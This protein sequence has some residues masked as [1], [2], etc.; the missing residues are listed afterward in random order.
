MQT[1]P[2]RAHEYQALEAL[3]ALDVLDT[4]PEAEFDA[5]VRVASLVC[6]APISLISLV[7]ADR[8]WFKANLGLPGVSETP[9]DVAFCAHAV[10]GDE[11]FEVQDA[12][13]D[14]RFADNPLVAGSP[15]I[16]FY[17]GAPLRLSDGSRIGT[18][19]VIDREPRRLNGTQREMLRL[20]AGV[21]SRALEQRLAARKRDESAA[22]VTQVLRRLLTSE[23]WFRAL[24]ESSPLGVYA[25]DRDGACTYTNARW[26]EIFGLTQEQSLGAGWSAGIHPDDRAGVYTEWQ[27]AV[28]AGVE[29]DLQCRLLHKDGTVR[30]VRSRARGVDGAEGAVV[31]FVGSL[32][33]ITERRRIEAELTRQ[34]QLLRVTLHSIGDAVITT[35]AQGAVLWLNPAAERLTGWPS[36]EAAGRPVLEVFNIV[37][38]TTRAPAPDPVA[39]CLADARATRPAQATALVARDGTERGIE[40]SGAPIRSDEGAVLGVVLVFRDVTER[41]RLAAEISHRAT[42]DALTGLVNR[43]ELELRVRQELA[44]A[45]EDGGVHALLAIDLDQFKI[46]NDACGHAA[47]DLL[48]QQV[49]KLLSSSVRAHDTVARLGGD[50]FA[51]ILEHCT[52]AQAQGVAQKICDRM[53]DHRFVHEGRQFRVGTSIGLVPLDDRWASAAPILQAA[54]AACYAAKEAGR[55]RVHVWL[56]S[57]DGARA[58][59]GNVHWHARIEHALDHGGFALYG[60]EIT[61]L[62]SP[63]AGR[64]AEAF[65]RLVDA[66]GMLIAPRAF[67]PAAERARL[68]PRIDR[69]VLEDV[70]RRLGALPAPDTVA[71]IGVNVC[72]QSIE[73]SAFRV[74]LHAALVEAGPGVSRRLFLEIGESAALANLADT[75]PFVAMVRSLGVRVALDDFGSGPASFGHLETMPVDALKIDGRFTRALA[76]S[77]LQGAAIRCFVEVARILGIDTVAKLVEDRPTLDRLRELGVDRAQGFL[78]QRPIQLDRLFDPAAPPG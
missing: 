13:E 34:A 36:G 25:T 58:R 4:P 60:Q 28:A 64:H 59:R 55:N 40:E 27:R 17:A 61:T 16:R 33:D 31:A 30:F 26:Q 74:W 8:Q 22:A 6:G 65:L 44:R 63:S 62:T 24:S 12:E 7:D 23:G 35:D 72:A 54:D 39:A 66:D 9:R 48:L 75:A 77:P 78:I 38:E 68:G 76:T 56:D 69:W 19:C 52:L 73:D 71:S 50:E 37:D 70:I 3:L 11:L 5:L 51:I 57:E 14:P 20:L 2:P 32:E 10:L 46:V 45:Q 29:F 18:L 42:H 43:A 47:G 15:D 1:A 41:R 49:S 53:A 21:A 67:L